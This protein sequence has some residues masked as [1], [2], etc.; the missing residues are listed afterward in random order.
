M[1]IPEQIDP[2]N[3]SDYLEVMTRAVFQASL[4]WKMI[5]KSW[6]AHKSAFENFAPEKVASFTEE[7]VERLMQFNGII[8]SKKKIA[9]TVKNAKA[10][11]ELDRQYGGFKNYL[12]SKSSYAE[13]CKDMRK[14][15][16]FLGE[17]SIYYFLF[18]VKEPVPEF[19]DWIKTIE[20]DHPR[21]REMVEAACKQTKNT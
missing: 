9:A 5:D 14:R 8:H 6:A 7:D 3:L 10:M 16:S 20:G 21:M 17:L 15:F 4:S 11:L 1:P 19:E 18:R 12:R 13:L 2:Q